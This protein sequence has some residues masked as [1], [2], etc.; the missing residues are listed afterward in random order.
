MKQSR[1]GMLMAAL[2]C[3]TIVPVLFGG[4]RAYAA[5]AEEE[6]VNAA[7]RGFTL[8]QIIVTAT[9]EEKRDVDVPA[10][11]EVLTREDI[12]ATGATNVA[13]A[14]SKLQGIQYKSFGV[15]GASMGTMTNEVNIRGV[16]SGVL[17][18]VNGNPIAWRGKY[19]LESI[20]AD[21]VERIEMVKG[22]GS[23]LYGSEAAGGVIN[24]IT[25]KK[26]DNYIKAGIG[27]Y[28]RK[29]YGASVGDDKIQV[30]YEKEKWDDKIDRISESDVTSSGKKYGETKTSINHV[31][32]ENAGLN[33]N[34]NKNLN[35]QYNYYESKADFIREVTAS[36]VAAMKVGDLFNN[37][38]Y[39][40]KQHLAQLNYDDKQ[41]KADLYFTTGT[42]E[43]LGNTFYS[44][45]GKAYKPTD[46]SYLYNTR[47]RN[48]RLGADVQ[49]TWHIGDKVSAILGLDFKHETYQTLPTHTTAVA[50]TIDA[51]RNIW[52][53]YGQWDQKIND[54]NEFILS[55][56]E[57]WTTS[58]TKGQNYNNFSGAGQF[59]HKLD[60]N[61]SLYVSIAQSFIMP[62]FNQ[63]YKTG[64]QQRPNPNL[65]PQHGLNYEIGWKKQ[66]GAH[67]WKVAA[68]YIDI[69]DNIAPTWDKKTTEWTY[70][71]EDFKNWG[72]E[73]GD[74]VKGK[75]PWS[76]NWSVSVG[77][78]KSKSNDKPYWDR[79]F[80]RYQ[81]TGGIGY[82]TEKFSA[83][84]SGSFLGDRVQTPS[85]DHSY[86]VRP[87]FLT[88]LTASYRPT[89]AHEFILTI[90]N[91][92]DRH[93][94]VT[95]SSSAYY[96][97]PINFLFEYKYK[98]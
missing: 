21:Q 39:T 9:R 2:I 81:I 24:I 17:V 70:T 91:V 90:D 18:L 1:K 59:I 64:Y 76:Y 68:Y 73:I 22:G 83:N 51:S 36:N 54:K 61:Q 89:K 13:G 42:V 15:A 72:I 84:F 43:S 56:R 62:H 53:L 80:G 92:L 71:N 85:K 74:T 10:S 45:T 5:E 69:K 58:A 95:H 82:N 87:Y 66:A 78:P 14:V 65:K 26:A 3:G 77:D 94:V 93:D 96:S 16:D 29:T 34:I 6:D 19:N 52:G 55:A 31:R 98:F 40:T 86:G 57:T 79:K 4:T 67:N 60:E 48:R 20:Q 27:N 41:W 25:K 11:T 47:E 32:R 49:R 46:A 38:L 50:D 63:M 88:T 12:K 7:L 28:G 37:R 97:T 30:Y 8:D 33:Y 35:L 44:S 23:V 75:S